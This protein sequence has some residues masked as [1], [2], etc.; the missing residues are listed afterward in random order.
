MISRMMDMLKTQWILYRID[1]NGNIVEM[2]RFQD[3]SEA[4]QAMKE[5]DAKGHKQKYLIK[6]QKSLKICEK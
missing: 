3:Q 2:K 6:D 5:Y 1:D 4:E